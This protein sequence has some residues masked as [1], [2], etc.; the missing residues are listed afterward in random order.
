MGETLNFLHLWDVLRGA[1]R[2]ELTVS[3][4][5]FSEIYYNTRAAIDQHNRYRWDSLKVEQKMQTKSWDKRVTSSIFGVYCV[6]AWLMYH[7][8]TTDTI[9]KEPDLNQQ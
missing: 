7:G 4:P 2:Q 9:H 6:D 8:C 1:E 5:K 3:Q